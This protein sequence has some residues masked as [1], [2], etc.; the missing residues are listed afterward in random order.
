[1]NRISTIWEPEHSGYE[2]N[3]NA[4]ALARLGATIELLGH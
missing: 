1:M 4:D 3:D 2:G